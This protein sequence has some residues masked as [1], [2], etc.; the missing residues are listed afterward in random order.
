MQ[1]HDARLH[2]PSTMLICGP[3]NSG[4]TTFTKKIL[5]HSNSLFTPY[6][7]KFVV[8]VYETWQSCYDEMLQNNY[9]HLAIKGLSDIDYLKEIFEENKSKTS[10]LLVIDDQMQNIDQNVVSIFTIYSHHYRVSCL[11]VTQSLFLSN[12]FYR[13]VSLNSNYIVLMK[14]TRDNS[15]V[16]HVGKQTHP[17]KTRFITDSYLDATKNPYTHLLFD[18]RQETPEEIRI[19]GNIFCDPITVY[20]P[21]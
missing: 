14:N 2:H 1:L 13:T 9:I 11:L 3:S 16:T 19:R 21:R 17:F 12:K 4:K 6:P 15:S 20:F 5:K 7:P 8:L 18:L 10:T